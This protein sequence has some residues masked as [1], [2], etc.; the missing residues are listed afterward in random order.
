M[1]YVGLLV[2]TIV[3]AIFL[4]PAVLSQFSTLGSNFPRYISD[5]PDLL[6]SAQ[7]ELDKLNLEI[8][9]KSLYPPPDLTEQAQELGSIIAQTAFSIAARIANIA[10][11]LLLVYVLSFYMALDGRKLLDILKELIP[12]Q[13]QD[14]VA[15]A[16]QT[17]D[18]VFGAFI[19]GEL[20]IGILYGLGAFMA[21][22]FCNLRFSLAIASLTAFITLIPA[23][24]EPIAMLLPG[25]IA[26]I[27][28]SR[29][30]IPLLIAMTAYQQV[31]LR[32]I[33]PRIMSEMVGM[34]SLLTLAAIMI[35][36]RLIGF[37]G[38]VFGIPV[39]GALYTMGLFFLERHSLTCPPPVQ[40]G[41]GK[42][43]AQATDPEEDTS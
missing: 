10:T 12:S 30:V 39:A 38:F 36:V 37:W 23:L 34:P 18:R 13:Y 28:G 11:S 26:L 31:L 22:S 8:N 19:R 24:G 35:S 2:I 14:E 25:L 43:G 41:A 20:L 4:I 16:S 15:F 1:V 9:L 33:M 42:Q 7:R 29:A 17:I 40:T 6:D 32:V 21:M 27:Q 5:M 3:L